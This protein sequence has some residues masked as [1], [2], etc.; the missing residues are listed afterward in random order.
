M[1]IVRVLPWNLHGYN[2]E[3]IT[4]VQCISWSGR[5]MRLLIH[6]IIGAVAGCAMG[7]CAPIAMYMLLAFMDPKGMQQGGGTPFAIMLVITPQIGAIAGAIWG[8]RAA[9]PPGEIVRKGSRA[10]I[11]TFE[12]DFGYR[13]DEEQWMELSRVLPGWLRDYRKS[14]FWRI[15]IILAL[16]L[17]IRVWLVKLIVIG[18]LAGIARL[19]VD[20]RSGIQVVRTRWGDEVVDQFAPLPYSLRTYSKP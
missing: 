4:R 8:F 11:E 16:T 12:N 1:V 19:V 9:L 18:C 14:L 20:M 10:A 13:S 6:I 15:L 5:F 2:L 3:G 17:L 7:I